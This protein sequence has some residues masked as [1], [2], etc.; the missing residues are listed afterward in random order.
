[1]F[2]TRA[3]L[4]LA[5]AFAGA[6]ADLTPAE[7]Q[8]NTDSFEQVWKAVRDRHWEINPGGLDWQA[9]H[10]ELRPQI[11][12]AKSIAEARKIMSGMLGRLHQTHFGI[13]PADVYDE[14]ASP[15]STEGQPGIDVRALD[16]HA[17]VTGVEPDSPAAKA[18][19]K[20]GW[21]ILR[22]ENREMKEVLQLIQKNFKDSTLLD[23]RL[24]RTVL[25]HLT[26]PV[27]ETVHVEFLDGGGQHLKV[28]LDRVMPRGTVVKLGSFPP[29][30]FWLE[31]KK[32]R[33]DVAYIRFNAFF[34]PDTVSG[35]FA[36]AVKSCPN[37]SGFVVDLRGNP[38]GLGGLAMGVGGWFIDQKGLQ[39]GTM[40]MRGTKL[41]FVLFPRPEPFRGPLAVLVDGCS[42]STSEIF[43]GGFKDIHR[44]RI[45]GTRTAGAALPSTFEKLPNG[46]GFQYAIA[47]YI[48]EGGQPLEGIGVTPD[49]EV[50]LTRSQLLEGQDPVLAAAIEWIRTQKKE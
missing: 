24:S 42:G 8:A 41:N 2:A 6:A 4:L 26:G 28:A 3:A 44:A 39:L 17:I 15:G 7:R 16:G 43:A 5:I 34:D 20:P 50:K 25:Y 18:G 46:D 29:F 21:E 11:D 40:M 12:K 30:Y 9:V 37:C 32:V 49:E 38:G 13:F 36:D 31:S 33:P 1:M 22:V 19:V 10:D 45:F 27:N 14:F 35:A 48:S 23:L 47:N